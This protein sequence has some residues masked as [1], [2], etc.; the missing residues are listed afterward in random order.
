MCGTAGRCSSVHSD[1]R[2]FSK[3]IPRNGNQ[4][5]DMIKSSKQTEEKRTYLRSIRQKLSYAICS[6]QVVLEKFRALLDI[7]PI[8][9]FI[10]LAHWAH[11]MCQQY[12]TC[13][14]YIS[15]RGVPSIEYAS[16]MSNG[17]SAGL[18]TNKLLAGV[19]TNIGKR[20][21]LPGS[22]GCLV[23]PFDGAV[24]RIGTVDVQRMELVLKIWLRSCS[25]AACDSPHILF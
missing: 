3:I 18:I 7:S 4:T 1:R 16:T 9:L 8:F 21:D 5:L 2:T 22:K 17:V 14:L 10:C 20:Q 25:Q 23:S 15:C 19:M 6:I 12:H 24:S 11:V 13:Q